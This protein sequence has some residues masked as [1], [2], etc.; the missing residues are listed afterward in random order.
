M[1]GCLY[2][3]SASNVGPELDNLVEHVLHAAR[4]ATPVG[5]DDER[6]ALPTE[7]VDGLRRLE[8]RV[9]EPDLARLWSSS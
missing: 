7:V 6:Q 2:S 4:E 1:I 3:V 8:G 5:Q 9:R